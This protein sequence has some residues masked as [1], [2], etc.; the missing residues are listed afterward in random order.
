MRKARLGHVIGGRRFGYMN[1]TVEKHDDLV[2]NEDERPFVERIFDLCTTGTGYTRI[3]K[4]LN[5]EGARSP[6]PQQGR[7]AGWSPSTVRAVLHNPLYRGELVT[8]KTKKRDDSGDVAPA[9]R[10]A[11]EW[12]RVLRE[13][14][15]IVS[16]ESG[17]RHTR[18]CG[19]RGRQ[20]PRRSGNAPWFGATTTQNTC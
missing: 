3:A 9:P 2:I 1:I 16:D 11:S 18:G 17:R 6:R 12:V 19:E 15:R 13:D 7:P 20:W 8:F 10:P 5:A 14:L 4:T